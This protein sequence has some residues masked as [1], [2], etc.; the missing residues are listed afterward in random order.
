MSLRPI[1]TKLQSIST[2]KIP[3]TGA[4]L[5]ALSH[6]LRHLRLD[7]LRWICNMGK[8]PFSRQRVNLTHHPFQ[9]SIGVA[10]L[11]VPWL[12][13][14]QPNLERPIKVNLIW[15]V[16][17]LL[18]TIFVTAVRMVASPVVTWIGLLM[19]LTSIPVYLIFIYWENKPQWFVKATN[20]ITVTLQQVLIVVGKSKAAD[21]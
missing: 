9:L 20:K 18:C 8:P 7:Q 11:C 14:T 3:F 21:L 15:P 6:R 4:T 2:H 5:D 19:I 1:T 16:I 13:W 12:R 17:Y 10:V